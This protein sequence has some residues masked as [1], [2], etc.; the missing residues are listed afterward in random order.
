MPRMPDDLQAQRRR[1][2]GGA[3][4]RALR[5]LQRDIR[6]TAHADRAAAARA[7]RNAR[8]APDA[9][10]AAA[11]R[12][13]RFSGRIRAQATLFDPEERPR[14]PERPSTPAFTRRRRMRVRDATGRGSPAAYCCCSR[15]PDKSPGPSGRAGSTMRACAPGSMPACANARLRTAAAARRRRARAPF[16]RHPPASFGARCADHLGDAAQRRRFRA[17]VSDRRDH[18][19]RSR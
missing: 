13:C 1:S 2:R 7:D 4:Q 12:I 14:A 6:C 18:P 9:G 3:R 16:A 11:A 15:S 5:A 17:G 10:R 8:P 19:V